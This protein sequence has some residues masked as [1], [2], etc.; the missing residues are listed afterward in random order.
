[1]T[2]FYNKFYRDIFSE[3][4]TFKEG[5]SAGTLLYDFFKPFR[6]LSKETTG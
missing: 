1:M 4:Y 5:D 2:D 6:I 3:F